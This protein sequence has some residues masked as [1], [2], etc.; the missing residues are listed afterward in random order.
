MQVAFR[1]KAMLAL[2]DLDQSTTVE[3]YV[4]LLEQGEIC[5]PLMASLRVRIKANH[6]ATQRQTHSQGD[7][8]QHS[9]QMD[10]PFPDITA[11][12]VEAMPLSFHGNPLIPNASV[13]II[14]ALLAATHEATNE[15]LLTSTLTDIARSPFYNMTING[16]PAEKALV[17]LHF[18]QRSLGASVANGFRV[19]TENV[20]DACDNASHTNYRTIALCSVQ[21]CPDF[22]VAKGAFAL[23]VLCKVT[24]PAKKQHVA[25]IYIETLELVPREQKDEVV[26]TIRSLQGVWD[27]TEVPQPPPHEASSPCQQRKCRKLATYPTLGSQ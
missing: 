15:R 20:R 19:V 3:E 17:F 25:D 4:G 16:Q 24:A 6:P 27:R 18:T 13:D 9:E 7:A 2:A 5:P 14:H 10:R 1:A 26:G 21:R 11:V 12:V 8:T 22:T 23:A